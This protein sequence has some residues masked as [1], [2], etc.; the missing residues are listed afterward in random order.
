MLLNGE[1]SKKKTFFWMNKIY[2]AER[3]SLSKNGRSKRCKNT[4]GAP[5]LHEFS[6][7]I[8]EE[9]CEQ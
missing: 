1:K 7:D 9:F 8:E 5:M 2:W 4:I 6:N 3:L